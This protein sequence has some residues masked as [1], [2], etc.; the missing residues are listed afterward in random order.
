M[1]PHFDTGCVRLRRR[2]RLA[3]RQP[4]V[5]SRALDDA[6]GQGRAVAAAITDADEPFEDASY[7]WSDQFGL[8]LQHLGH[9]DSWHVVVLEGDENAFTARYYDRDGKLLAALAANGATGVAS[10]RRELAA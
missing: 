10:L 5:S 4:T 6:A 8:R 1:R 3:A 9:A 7:F 2:S